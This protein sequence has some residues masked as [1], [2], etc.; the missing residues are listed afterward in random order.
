MIKIVY[1]K[2]VDAL[3]IRFSDKEID[4]SDEIAE[5]FVVDFDKDGEIV[6]IEMLDVSKKADLSKILVQ[7]F[8][9]V[10]VVG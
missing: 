1:S 9:D 10:E 3:Y 6:A 5:G 7:Y 4:S 2:D 8:K